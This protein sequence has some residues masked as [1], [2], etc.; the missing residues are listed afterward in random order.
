M[1]LDLS[2]EDAQGQCSIEAAT[3]WQVIL[4]SRWCGVLWL[5]VVHCT[6][7]SGVHW[8]CV[9]CSNAPGEQK[10]WN[11]LVVRAV[12]GCRCTV[13]WVASLSCRC[14]CSVM[15]RSPTS[16]HV[17]RSMGVLVVFT[18]SCCQK[19]VPSAACWWAGIHRLDAPVHNFAFRG[20]CTC[21]WV[22][23]RNCSM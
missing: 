15:P 22:C 9:L 10:V 19:A 21:S 5:R 6:C 16:M 12:L 23:L 8:H 1:A 11:L 20:L 13:A 14:L 2:F 7:I 18:L 17:Y 3:M 4:F